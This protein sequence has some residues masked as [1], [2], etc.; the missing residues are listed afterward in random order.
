M[1]HSGQNMACKYL[2][3]G[4]KFS[5]KYYIWNLSMGNLTMWPGFWIYWTWMWWFFIACNLKAGIALKERLRFS[6]YFLKINIMKHKWNVNAI[7]IYLLLKVSRVRH[8]CLYQWNNERLT[9]VKAKSYKSLPTW[10][11]PGR[12]NYFN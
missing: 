12:H 6:N 2:L 8:N 4:F 1:A 11:C 10:T 3:C 7:R 5:K 9:G